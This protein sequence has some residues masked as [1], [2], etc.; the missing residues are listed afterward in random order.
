MTEIDAQLFGDDVANELH[1]PY[2]LGDK[3]TLLGLFKDAG[4]P[5]V[6]LTT[7]EGMARFD[8]IK[9]WVDLDVEG[10]TLGEIIGPDGHERLLKA[11]EDE[12][13]RFVQ[14]DGSV[15]FLSPS[16]LATAVKH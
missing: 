3:H 16:H 9:A 4:I 7:H 14:S 12:L 13:Q 8:S 11:A 6:R 10:W 15:A 2:S 5:G 1:T